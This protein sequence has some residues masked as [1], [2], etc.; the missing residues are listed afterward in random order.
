MITTGV[1][2]NIIIIHYHENYLLLLFHVDAIM[3]HIF[4][5]IIYRPDPFKIT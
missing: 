2:A 4:I 1:N 5:K 3:I